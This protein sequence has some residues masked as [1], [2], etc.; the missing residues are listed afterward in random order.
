MRVCSNSS[1]ASRKSAASLSGSSPVR[2]S[3]SDEGGGRH[4]PLNQPARCDRRRSFGTGRWTSSEAAS[5]RWIA[6]LAAPHRTC[7]AARQWPHAFLGRPAASRSVHTASATV[8]GTPSQPGMSSTSAIAR[9]ASYQE[10]ACASRSA[11]SYVRS[12]G[13]RACGSATRPASIHSGGGSSRRNTR[14]ESAGQHPHGIAHH[15][16]LN[17]DLAP[18]AAPACRT[19]LSAGRCRRSCS[20]RGRH[21]GGFMSSSSATL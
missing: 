11:P 17:P 9:C 8:T 14:D 16:I 7:A 18:G 6:R 10:R 2:H 4:R 21:R 3:R 12:L 20:R 19:S 13:T 15:R 1:K 5:R